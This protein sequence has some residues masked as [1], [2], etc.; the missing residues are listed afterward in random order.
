MR[1]HG[2]SQPVTADD[3]IRITTT[4]GTCIDWSD[5]RKRS[6]VSVSGHQ[7]STVTSL[8]GPQVAPW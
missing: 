6:L 8:T 5:K 3:I 7:T 1:A 2:A 4:D